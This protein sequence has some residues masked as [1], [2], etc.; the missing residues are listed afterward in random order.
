MKL[1]AL[2]LG[3]AL[4]GAALTWRAVRYS[5]VRKGIRTGLADLDPAIRIAAVHQAVELGLA[6]TAPA[7]LRAVRVETDPTV[8]AIVIESVASR[9]WE[10][11]STA[12]IVELRLW[13]KAYS[14]N[15]SELHRLS[16][17][18]E[19][20]LSGIAGVV[21]PPSLHP[22]REKEF[23]RRNATDVATGGSDDDAAAGPPPDADP[24]APVRV[25]V[26]GAGGAAGVSVIRALHDAGHH[27]IA[28]DADADAVGLRLADEGHVV[29]RF[30]D[31]TYLAA[32]IRIATVY[33]AQALICTVAEEYRALATATEFLEEAGVRTLMPSL[34][35]VQMSIDK[36]LFAEAMEAA[37]LPVPATGLGS[38]E[39]IAGPWIVK[40]R[41]GRGSRD[42]HAVSTK[43][44]LNAALLLTP[45]PI[46]QTQIRGREFTADALVY[47][48]GELCGVVP[49]WRLATKGG[50]STLGMTFDDH[51][52]ADVVGRVLKAIGH[53]GPANVQGFVTDD[54]SVVIVEVNPRF[55]G[56]LPLSLHA[57]ADLVG[58]YLRAIMGREPRSERLIARAGVTMYRYFDEVYDG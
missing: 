51:L 39:G 3:I 10:P 49:R 25:L 11:A 44:A 18:A 7:L 24:L 15:R 20:L 37:G 52:V 5:R 27:T 58:E 19:P 53:V 26:T 29:P 36:W 9:Q 13:A 22:L 54:G 4:I 48:A 56:G 2:L 35:T 23:Q 6:S 30:D 21:L 55:S 17:G 12:A 40:P 8:R 45:D 42:V 50:I 57:G 32:L 1:L 16:S 34:E 33:E 41:H 14:D 28:V 47:P 31:P 38:G 46:V 43:K